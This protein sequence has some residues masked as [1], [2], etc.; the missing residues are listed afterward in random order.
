MSELDKVLAHLDQNLD[1]A[2]ERLFAFLRIPS[3]S[4]DPAYKEHCVTAAEHLKAD[5]ASI[6]FDAS[7]RPTKGHPV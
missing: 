6:G 2:I 4:T 5:V 7:V 1:A 3:V